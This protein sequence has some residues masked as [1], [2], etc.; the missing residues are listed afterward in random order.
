VFRNISFFSFVIIMQW[1]AYSHTDFQKMVQ[2]LGKPF[3]A[4]LVWPFSG[5]FWNSISAARINRYSGDFGEM[6][7]YSSP[8][9]DCAK[10]GEAVFANS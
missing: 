5:M 9:K 4:I 8:Q 10:V 7:Q 6:E 2:N 1:I 3:C